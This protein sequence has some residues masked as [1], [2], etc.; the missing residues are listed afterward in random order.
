MN[1]DTRLL[2]RA[3]EEELFDLIENHLSELH[4]SLKND[5]R[6]YI[7]IRGITREKETEEIQQSYSISR[8]FSSSYLSSKVDLTISPSR[9]YDIFSNYLNINDCFLPATTQYCHQT[10]GIEISLDMEL[11]RDA[12]ILMSM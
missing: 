10:R 12:K 2:L 7:L 4:P 9:A 8:Y 3:A 6:L 1:S 5:K 11:M